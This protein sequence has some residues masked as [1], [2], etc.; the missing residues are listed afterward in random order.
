[1]SE[2]SEIFASFTSHAKRAV[3]DAQR[4]ARALGHPH[5]GTAHLLM[6][7]VHQKRCEHDHHSLRALRAIGL[8][9]E[10]I[11][12]DVVRA[13]G[14]RGPAPDE[15]IPATPTHRKVVAAAKALSRIRQDEFVC[16]GHLLLGMA[17]Q[18]ASDPPAPASTMF[19]RKAHLQDPAFYDIAQ[20]LLIDAAGSL[21]RVRGAVSGTA[22]AATPD[23]AP[24][25]CSPAQCG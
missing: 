18:L 12:P 9:C 13:L 16:T 1:M 20:R 25:Y 23:S 11:C 6:A 2:T 17:H 19:R 3:V 15:R 5:V 4:G 24:G 14:E 21:E 22:H 10:R 7:L 8:T